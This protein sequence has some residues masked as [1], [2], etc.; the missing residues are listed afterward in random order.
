MSLGGRTPL[1][2]AQAHALAD[3]AGRFAYDPMGFVMW[4]YPWGTGPLRDDP[5]PDKWQAELLSDLKTALEEGV[6]S[7]LP[8][9]LQFAVSSGHGV[10]KTA[11]V[12]WII[13]WFTSTREH[14]QVVVTANTRTQLLTKTWRELA[15]WHRMSMV[16]DLFDWT[17]TSFKHVIYP[18]TWFAS[19]IPWSAH[20]S[21]AFAGTHE[22]FVL[23]LFDEASLIDDKIWEVTEGAMTT[24]GAMWFVFGNPTKNSGRF[25]ACFGKFKHRWHHYQVD[26]RNA[27]KADQRKIQQWKDD[28]GE[29]SDFFRVRVRG[30]FPRASTL[31]FISFEEVTQAQQRTARG[32]ETYAKVMGIDVARH[33]D[34]QSVFCFRQQLKTWPF[35]RHRIQDL[36]LL[37]D[38]AA[39]EIAAFDPDGVFIDVTGM[40]WGVY[41]NLRRRPKIKDRLYAVQVGEAAIDPRRFFNRRM[42]LWYRMREW[43]REGGTLPATIDGQVDEEIAADLTGPE[44]GFATTEKMQ[45]ERKED[46][47]ERGLASPDSGDS[48]AIT[49]ASSVEPRKT[50]QET[51]M[52]K[53]AKM[54]AKARGE[55]ESHQSA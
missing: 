8:E 48:L 13:E 23:V 1:T 52:M 49:F 14:P 17:A 7:T 10:G 34:D 2:A 24:A 30:V 41:D 51:T 35:K 28:Y 20:A 38:V 32:F 26:A 36:M 9:A 54:R 21:E 16:R 27:R 15:K 18:E 53:L 5:G 40:G 4:A 3:D 22:K 50:V 11:F 47:K 29:D 37:A 55:D 39:E 6:V 43:L 31:Q 19:A 25:H 44:Y 45:L 12:A 46:M 33:G 42:E